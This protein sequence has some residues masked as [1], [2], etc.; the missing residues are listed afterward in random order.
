[1]ARRRPP[2][3]PAPAGEPDLFGAGASAPDPFGA[4]GGEP[5]PFGAGASGPDPFGMAGGEPDPFG[6]GASAPD[7]FGAAG[8]EPDPFGAGALAPDPP[9]PS[10]AG[11]APDPFG[12]GDGEAGGDMGSG[13]AADG[14]LELD[15]APAPDDPAPDPFDPGASA[16]DAGAGA[17]DGELELDLD[18]GGSPDAAAPA[19]GAAPEALGFGDDDPFATLDAGA[20]LGGG[21]DPDGAMA[22]FDLGGPPAASFPAASEAASIPAPAAPPRPRAPAAAPAVPPDPAPATPLASPPRKRGGVAVL[23]INGLFGLALVALLLGAFVASRTGSRFTPSVF[24]P[25]RLRAAFT[26]ASAPGLVVTRFSNGLYPTRTGGQV[27]VVRGVATNNGDQAARPGR[28]EVRLVGPG[29][30]VV[31][32]TTGVLGADPSAAEV[33]RLDGDDAARALVQALGK[34]APAQVK[35]HAH[36]SFFAVIPTWHGDLSEMR[37]QVKVEGAG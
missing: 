8:G 3:N 4:A 24:T 15:G 20:E 14:P 23:A 13:W 5:D 27:L 1:M 33:W 31:A 34:R 26:G 28:V 2:G 19:A 21:P 10:G 12:G 7:P 9:E 35:A 25:A 37:F 16:L 6:A 29:G 18:L 36:V 30:K 22:G 32:S 17:A 11:T